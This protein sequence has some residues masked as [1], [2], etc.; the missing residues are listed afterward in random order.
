MIVGGLVLFLP[1]DYN[2]YQ[3]ETLELESILH[4]TE[5]IGGEVS[6]KILN[7]LTNIS[8]DVKNSFKNFDLV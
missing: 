1:D 4:N 5:N 7:S 8:N 2:F 3:D 6:G